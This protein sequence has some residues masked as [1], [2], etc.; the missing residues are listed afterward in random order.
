ASGLEIY[1]Q[2]ISLA[3]LEAFFHWLGKRNAVESFA[4]HVGDELTL[5]DAG[6]PVFDRQRRESQF[7]CQLCRGPALDE[8]CSGA[9]QGAVIIHFI[10]IP[11]PMRFFFQD[12]K[13]AML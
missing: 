3:L 1:L 8:S 4:P 11:A 12:E 9:I 10:G 7:F 6:V 2:H 13:I 5:D